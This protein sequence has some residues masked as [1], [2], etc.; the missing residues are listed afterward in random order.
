MNS[1]TPTAFPNST[2]DRLRCHLKK[3][4]TCRLVYNIDFLCVTVSG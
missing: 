3:Q 1:S 2:N 4:A